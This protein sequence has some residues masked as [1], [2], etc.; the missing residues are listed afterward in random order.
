MIRRLQSVDSSRVRD[1]MSRRMISESSELL[2]SLEIDQKISES[3]GDKS[4]L[5]TGEGEPLI[6]CF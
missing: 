5:L 6:V 3:D 2:K 1:D 4:L